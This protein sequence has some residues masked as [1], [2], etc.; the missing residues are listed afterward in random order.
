M[1]LQT[2][3]NEF[4]QK[5]IKLLNDHGKKVKKYEIVQILKRDFACSDLEVDLS[6]ERLLSSNTLSRTTENEYFVASI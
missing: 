6:I 3:L 2:D 4:D 5:V 1:N